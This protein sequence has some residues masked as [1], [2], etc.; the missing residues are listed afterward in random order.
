ML[1]GKYHHR[2]WVS[3]V[4]LFVFSDYIS[5]QNDSVISAK[6]DTVFIT[7]T[8]TI[9]IEKKD[10][11][12]IDKNSEKYY[13]KDAFIL[14]GGINFND[15][16]VSSSVYESVSGAGWHLGIMYKRESFFYWQV[17]AR[18][19]QAQYNLYLNNNTDTIRDAFSVT[20]LD[21]P[22]TA[23][24]NFLPFAKRALNIHVFVSVAPSF[25]LNVGGNSLGIEKDDT[26]TFKLYGQGGVGVDIF[27]FVLEGGFNFG[28]NDLLKDS[29]SKPSQV[30]V[31]LGF[32][33]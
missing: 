22:V 13:R 5:A 6:P 31:S 16:K 26:N 30:F 32:R 28:F 12:F 10:T 27:S 29:E 17:G 9:F 18:L 20:D 19:N 2:I 33:F 7:K 4:F 1:P 23:G 25:E 3:A 15:L 24:L 21:I 14:Y 11:V 8:D